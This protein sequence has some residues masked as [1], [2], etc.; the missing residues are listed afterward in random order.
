MKY[1][2]LVRDNIPEIIRSKG[3]TS[4]IHIADEKE[5]E[6]KL[7]K[8]LAEEVEEFKRDVNEEELADIFEVVD[9][10]ITL[11]GFKKHTIEEI[12]QKKA[13]ERGKFEKRIILDESQG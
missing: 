5:Y 4:V 10:I 11:K 3:G 6:E 7:I 8:K 9:A 13:L 12:Q 1:E 2:K